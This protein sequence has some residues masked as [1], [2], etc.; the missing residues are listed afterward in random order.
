MRVLMAMTVVIGILW[1]APAHGFPVTWTAGVNTLFFGPDCATGCG[2]ARQ[3]DNE[4]AIDL[5]VS[6]FRRVTN[7]T[8]FGSATVNATVDVDGGIVTSGTAF[9]HA[10]STG[11]AVGPF[12]FANS[13]F[14]LNFMPDVA[15][16]V[17]LQLS[18]RK[19]GDPFPLNAIF[20]SI[21]SLDPQSSIF[22]FVRGS[23]PSQFSV[24][25]HRLLPAGSYVSGLLAFVD[26]RIAFEPEHFSDTSITWNLA[27]TV[28]APGAMLLVLLGMLAVVVRG[29]VAGGRDGTER[30][31]S[32]SNGSDAD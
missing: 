5:A 21:Q 1:T 31:L 20:V 4:P 22:S 3:S 29:S 26:E 17:D 19:A 18:A 16:G 32:F 10:E 9:S 25:F 30:G 2:P 11:D 14:M 12:L 27:I 8:L 7:G 15:V 13:S 24:E 28:P 6:D 23:A